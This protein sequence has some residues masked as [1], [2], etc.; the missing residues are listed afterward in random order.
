MS[1]IKEHRSSIGAHLRRQ[2]VAAK[3]LQFQLPTSLKGTILDFTSGQNDRPF[4]DLICILRDSEVKDDDLYSLLRNAQ[5]CVTLQDQNLKFF[6]QVLLVVKWAHRGPETVAAFQNLLLD[7]CSAHCYHTKAVLNHLVVN[8]KEVSEDDTDRPSDFP[9]PD[10]EKI[11][12]NVH[13]VLKKLLRVIPMAGEQLVAAVISA[14][15]YLKRST[16]EHQAYVHNMLEI[17]KY[18][19]KFRDDFLH[20]VV[21]KMVQLDVSAP[22]AAIEAAEEDVMDLDTEDIFD[23]EKDQTMKLPIANTLDHLMLMLFKFIESECTDSKSGTISP[24]L[25]FSVFKVFLQVF[26]KVILVTHNTHHVQF[27]LWYICSLKP[28]LA[29]IFVKHMWR[30]VTGVQVAPVT[31]QSAA[32]YISSFLARAKFIRIEYLKSMLQEMCD[33]MHTYINNQDSRTT[34]ELRAHAV[35]YSVCQAVFYLL[36]FRHKDLFKTRQN[37]V[38]LRGLNLSRIVTCGLN[39]LRVC[40]PEIVTKFASI[41]RTYQLVLCN[42]VIERNRRNVVPIVH[43]KN[44][45]VLAD[46]PSDWLDTFFPFDPYKLRKSSSFINPHYN[47]YQESDVNEESIAKAENNDEDD[48]LTEPMSV[49]VSDKRF[50][51]GTSPGFLQDQSFN[52]AASPRYKAL[53]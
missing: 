21:N 28:K 13:H 24:E 33:W 27:L 12:K 6:I 14:F 3:Q 20:L 17:L 44:H 46:K 39:P 48:F 53:V 41:T 43:S 5:D 16:R 47:V 42:S 23:T 7:L 4:K 1:T 35:F 19:P 25:S 36:C 37:M 50:S 32:A 49:S 10:E 22:R 34:V 9:S 40:V 8:L 31:R 30:L 29:E 38:F 45:V 26:E 18:E 51:Y 52:P 11:Y 15:P 2:A